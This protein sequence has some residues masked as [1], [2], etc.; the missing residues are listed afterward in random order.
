M[1][2]GG[3]RIKIQIAVRLHCSNKLNL[4]TVISRPEAAIIGGQ[5]VASRLVHFKAIKTTVS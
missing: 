4:T 5:R 2:C 3:Q 1:A